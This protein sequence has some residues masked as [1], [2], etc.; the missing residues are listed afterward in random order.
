MS[1]DQDMHRPTRDQTLMSVAHVYSQRSTCSRNYVGAVISIEGR[2]IATGY[3]GAPAGMFHCVHSFQS[4][5]SSALADSIQSQLTKAVD[6]GCKLAVHAEANAIAFAA[7]HGLSVNG[8]TMHTTL[9]P[10]Y[11]CAQLIIN[12]G[13][14]EVIFNSPY[15]NSEGIDLIQKAG[16]P[17]YK[18]NPPPLDF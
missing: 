10:C 13:I 11:N 15:R 5:V 7:R 3:N 2:I 12:A 16:I 14:E 17:I 18:L 6:N 4:Q 1:T 9:S 8:A